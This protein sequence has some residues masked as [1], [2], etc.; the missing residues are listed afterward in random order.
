MHAGAVKDCA[1]KAVTTGPKPLARLTLRDAQCAEA[2][3]PRAAAC[4]VGQRRNVF[5]GITRRQDT[6]QN[7]SC[8]EPSNACKYNA[9]PW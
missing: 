7:G 2:P 1:A 8:K 3:R 9:P 5:D 6:Q 4:V